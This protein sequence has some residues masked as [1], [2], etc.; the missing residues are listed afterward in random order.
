MSIVKC[1]YCQKPTEYE[2][3]EYRPFCSRR[4]KLLD[5]GAWIDEEYSVAGGTTELE[6]LALLDDILLETE[7]DEY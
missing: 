2:G 1:P 5:L 4:C 6:D 3:N 7:Q